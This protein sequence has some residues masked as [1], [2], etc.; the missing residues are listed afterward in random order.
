MWSRPDSQDIRDRQLA[1]RKQFKSP[2]VCIKQA[3]LAREW[4]NGQ[5]SEGTRTLFS[6][7]SF[8]NTLVEGILVQP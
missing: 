7:I 3:E 8:L 1:T 4:R 5:S 2:F 6:T